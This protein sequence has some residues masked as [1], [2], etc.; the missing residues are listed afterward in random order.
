MRIETQPGIG[1]FQQVQLA[2]AHMTAAAALATQTRSR[3]F[4][5]FALNKRDPPVVGA[6]ATSKRSFHAIGTPS[7]TDRGRRRRYRASAA[8][9]SFLARAG[10]TVMNIL[11]RSAFSIRS[12]RYS[13][14][15]TGPVSHCDRERRPRSP[16]GLIFRRNLSTLPPVAHS[17]GN[18]VRSFPRGSLSATTHEP[19]PVASDLVASLRQ[20]QSYALATSTREDGGG[21]R[22]LSGRAAIRQRYE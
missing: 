18:E 4:G 12:S 16:Y 21:R 17:L 7:R 11:S 5:V 14:R 3:S 22:R 9:A 15:A 8:S 20:L 10:V 1:K 19:S 2:H 6:S 13:I